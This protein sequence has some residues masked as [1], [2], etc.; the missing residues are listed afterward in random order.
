ML[1]DPRSGRKVR[2]Q[3]V[4]NREFQPAA[5]FHDRENRR[6]LRTCP[7]TSPRLPC[8][9]VHASSFTHRNHEGTLTPSSPRRF[10]RH[11]LCRRLRLPF[12]LPPSPALVEAG[13]QQLPTDHKRLSRGILDV[14]CSCPM[15][16][17]VPLP[18]VRYS[19]CSGEERSEYPLMEVRCRP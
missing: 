8:R 18:Y 5:G 19:Q 6:D 2:G 11:P 7:R 15:V 16:R 13:H 1:G 3:I 9:N 10:Y 12:R 17:L 14:F 4:A